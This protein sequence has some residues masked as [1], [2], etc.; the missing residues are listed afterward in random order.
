MAWRQ[1][2]D[3]GSAE[4]SVDF[5]LTRGHGSLFLDLYYWP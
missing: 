4:L 3:C 1:Y 5:V 2:L